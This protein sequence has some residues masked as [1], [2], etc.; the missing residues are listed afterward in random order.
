M[1]DMFT[2][3]HGLGLDHQRPVAGIHLR[4]R[5]SAGRLGLGRAGSP[6]TWS[7]A[8]SFQLPVTGSSCYRW[9][10]VS[11]EARVLLTAEKQAEEKQAELA[12]GVA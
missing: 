11:Q 6:L 3:A 1:G 12:V 9:T 7:I 4:E 8:M 2:G 5:A 10:A